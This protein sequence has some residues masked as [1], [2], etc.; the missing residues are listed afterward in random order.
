MTPDELERELA[1]GRLRPAYLLAGEEALLRDDALRAIRTLALAGAPA[2]WSCDVLEGEATAAGAF[3]DALRTLPVLGPRRLVVLREPVHARAGSAALVEMLVRVVPGLEA[4][5]PVVLVV[6]CA[7]VDRRGAWVRAFAEPRAFVDCAAPRRARELVEFVRREAGRQGLRLEAGAAELLAERVGPQLLVLR[8][9][10]A[11]LA[12]LTAGEAPVTRKD[13]ARSASDLAEEPIWDL[14][15]AIGEGRAADALALLHRMLAHG[16]PPP[17]VLA[18]LAS[19]LRKLV[20]VRHGGAVAGPP[21]VVRKLEEQARRT[22]PARLL[23]GLAA[24]HDADEILK[25]RGAIPAEIALERLVLS[26]AS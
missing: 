23:A 7:R 26:L 6:T 13:V 14:T 9:E 17:V 21:F 3:E 19:H 24:V 10:L 2:D 8:Q 4:P 1:A 15:D 5:E 18:A 16:A 20:R 11:K 12:L 25:G 22:R